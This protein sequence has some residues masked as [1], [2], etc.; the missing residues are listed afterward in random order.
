MKS[1]EAKGH[2][3]GEARQLEAKQEPKYL[4]S[5]YDKRVYS[6][7]STSENGQLV[8][9]GVLIEHTGKDGKLVQD[10]IPTTD[11]PANKKERRK[12]RAGLP[13]RTKCGN[14]TRAR[15]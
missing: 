8:K 5:A 14:L 4:V 1:F 9:V 3:L 11:E 15:P 7:P 10:I 12:Q 2:D 13:F 6:N